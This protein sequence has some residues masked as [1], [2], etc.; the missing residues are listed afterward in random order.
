VTELQILRVRALA[1]AQMGENARAKMFV[2]D[3]ARL[4]EKN[5]NRD[6]TERQVGYL[7]GLCWTYRRQIPATLRPAQNPYD[8]QLWTE[9][10]EGETTDDTDSADLRQEEL[11]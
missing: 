11:L 6:L 1:E 4:A 10:E 5:P 8:R 2:R 3:M 7:K 9:R